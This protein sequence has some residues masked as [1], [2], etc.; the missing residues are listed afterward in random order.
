M[1]PR[2][3]PQSNV[4]LRLD[5]GNEDNDLWAER[6]DE[7]GV[8]VIRSTWELSAADRQEIAEGANIELITW[9]VSHPPVALQT[10]TR[11]LGR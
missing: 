5:G 3:T 8:P 9:G 11:Q 1:K 4:V 7:E 2:R 6:S 10:T